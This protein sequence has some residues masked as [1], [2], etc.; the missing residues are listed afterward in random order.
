[1]LTIGELA[2][3]T[4]VSRRMLR[5]WEDHGLVTPAGT[6]GFTGHRRYEP[7]Q[8]GRV[9]TIAALRAV[10]FGLE[11][12]GQLLSSDLTEDRLISL[13][14]S[15]ESELVDQI[16]AASTRL[17]EVRTRLES[18]ERSHDLMTHLTLSAL[19]SVRLV[20][21]AE[22]VGDESEIPDAVQ[23][24]LARLPDS[25]TPHATRILVYDGTTDPDVITV[26]AGISRDDV[27]AA[28]H[29]LVGFTLP[30]VDNGAAL[31]YDR[32]PASIGDAW[33]ALDAELDKRGLRTT[34]PYRQILHAD[35]SVTLAAP[36]IAA[37][38]CA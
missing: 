5:H 8:A 12:I 20:G 28:S 9:R 30:A 34:G 23:R 33:I 32:A 19:P 22:D 26:T 18:I 14:R 17:R 29:G 35:G 7:R 4:G 27:H 3:R 1:M 11:E 36:S 15:K 24:L 37:H 16:A 21:V 13:L 38:D 25:G 2:Q 6:D 10:D 31:T